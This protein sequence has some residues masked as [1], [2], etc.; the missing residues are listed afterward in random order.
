MRIFA[1]RKFKFDIKTVYKFLR[2]VRK[3][4]TFFLICTYKYIVIVFCISK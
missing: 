1:C 3:R 4:L 2:V